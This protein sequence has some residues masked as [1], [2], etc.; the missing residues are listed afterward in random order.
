[1]KPATTRTLRDD[2]DGAI[3]PTWFLFPLVRGRRAVL[4]GGDPREPNRAR[5]ERVFQLA[6]LDWPAVY[7]QRKVDA[8][9]ARIRCGSLDLVF[10]LANLVSHKQA[11]AIIRAAKESPIPWALT[12]GYGVS[13]IKAALERFLGGPRRLPR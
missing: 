4:V 12:I 2:L 1:M 9:V 7:G 10:V 13:A 8:T 6:S 5:L 3:D 11:D